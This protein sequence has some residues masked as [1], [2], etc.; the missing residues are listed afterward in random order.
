MEETT[1]HG[2][3]AGCF[4]EYDAREITPLDVR[5]KRRHH[6]GGV[7]ELARS[8]AT[9]AQS[10][11]I[12]AQREADLDQLS[13]DGRVAFEPDHDR[14]QCTLVGDA[15]TQSAAPASTRPSGRSRTTTPDPATLKPISEAPSAQTKL[16]SF[17][18]ADSQSER[19]ERPAPAEPSPLGPG[20]EKE[21]S[22]Q[23][24]LTNFENE[25]S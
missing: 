7:L 8:L 9:V 15:N 18:D 11:G 6:V 16:W 12:P 13:D 2:I 22:E 21:A 14:R 3:P 20:K 23:S 10:Q 4:D 24:L 25:T 19:E 1:A 17:N 5:A